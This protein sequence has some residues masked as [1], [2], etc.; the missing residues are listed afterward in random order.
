MVPI[1]NDSD[2]EMNPEISKSEEIDN[3]MTIIINLNDEKRSL[4]V[5]ANKKFSELLSEILKNDNNKNNNYYIGICN[6][7][8]INE[9]ETLIENGIK[10]NDEVLLYSK[11]DKEKN[12][13]LPK[14]EEDDKEI[15]YSLLKVYQ[16]IKFAQY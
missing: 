13:N 7:K 10:N 16:A 1:M 15:L 3:K 6:Y 5:N 8:L 2:E 14:L 9:E 12:S 11:S 4:E